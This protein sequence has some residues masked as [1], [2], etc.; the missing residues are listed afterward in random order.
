[1]KIKIVNAGNCI[2]CGKPI[3]LVVPITT[4]NFAKNI[5]FC[6]KCEPELECGRK[7]HTTLPE[8]HD[9]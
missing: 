9:I 5:C 1:M 6:R 8:G 2:I 3:K 4:V 7:R